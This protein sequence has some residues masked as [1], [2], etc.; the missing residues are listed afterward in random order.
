MQQ[1]KETNI[2]V[3]SIDREF[4]S[5]G[6]VKISSYDAQFEMV[7]HMIVEHGYRDIH[8]VT[9]PL[10]NHEAELRYQAYQDALKKHG[11]RRHGSIRGKG[12]QDSK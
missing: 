7:E 2:P 12:I 6:C 9:G 11:I 4:D 3:V 8:Y 1:I 5:M 10:A